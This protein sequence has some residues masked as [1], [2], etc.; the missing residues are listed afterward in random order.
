[1]NINILEKVDFKRL[2]ELILS[3]CVLSDISLLEKTNFSKLDSLR[4]SRNIISHPIIV[5]V[6]IPSL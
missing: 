5:L 6:L 1:M 2:R 3:C 4:L